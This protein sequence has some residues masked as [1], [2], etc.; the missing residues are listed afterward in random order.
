MEKTIEKLLDEIEQLK[1]PFYR[2]PKWA[3][4]FA[5]DKDGEG[6][7][8]S[9]RPVIGNHTW[10]SNYPMMSA[11]MFPELAKNWENS[12]IERKIV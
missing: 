4:W 2:A 5:V 7:F 3:R 12:L 6:T 9:H 11:G 10:N 8:Y 1:D